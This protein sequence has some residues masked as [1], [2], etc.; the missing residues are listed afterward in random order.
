M[1][2]IEISEQSSV[3]FDVVEQNSVSCDVVDEISVSSDTD[4]TAK[5]WLSYIIKQF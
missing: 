5:F 3:S 1:D 2:S 4:L